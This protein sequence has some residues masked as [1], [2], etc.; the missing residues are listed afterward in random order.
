MVEGEDCLS[1]KLFFDLQRYTVSQGEKK[2]RRRRR[3]ESRKGEKRE[4][5]FFNHFR[6][7]SFMEFLACVN[8]YNSIFKTVLGE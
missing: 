5:F 2:R 8:S 3:K 4:F 7:D 1:C 6:G